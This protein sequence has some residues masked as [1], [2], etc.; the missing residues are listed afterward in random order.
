MI[1][2]FHRQKAPNSIHLYLF[3]YLFVLTR[4]YRCIFLYSNFYLN[5]LGNCSAL[6]HFSSRHLN[7]TE[8]GEDGGERKIPF[9]HG[10]TSLH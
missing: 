8:L 1:F 4:V 5:Y 10:H 9:L 7:L 3:M 6:F 2:F